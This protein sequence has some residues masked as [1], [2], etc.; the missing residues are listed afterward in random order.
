[1]PH[2]HREAG[3]AAGH[4]PDAKPDPRRWS[5][6]PLLPL[7]QRCTCQRAWIGAHT[8]RPGTRPGKNEVASRI[9]KPVPDVGVRRRCQGV[10][11]VPLSALARASRWPA[12]L[13]YSSA[14]GQPPYEPH[15]TSSTVTARSALPRRVGRNL[16]RT[17]VHAVRGIK[18]DCFQKPHPSSV[19]EKSPA[20]QQ[21]IP[22]TE[23]AGA[24]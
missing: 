18:H 3:C 9:K 22:A 5:D 10:F 23:S 24:A 20:S 19:S 21:A 14:T 7:S 17:V 11:P 4:K 6:G 15:T 2:P 12:P 1:M 16:R 8:P 13:I